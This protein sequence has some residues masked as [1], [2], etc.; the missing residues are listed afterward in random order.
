MQ[1]WQMRARRWESRAVE[2]RS[3]RRLGNG[4]TVAQGGEVSPLANDNGEVPAP[5]L[6]PEMGSSGNATS[7]SPEFAASDMVA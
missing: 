6:T 7:V 1:R 5:N 3:K 2:R 4:L